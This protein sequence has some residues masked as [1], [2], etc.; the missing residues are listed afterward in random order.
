MLEVV[1]RKGQGGTVKDGA[2][3]NI[4]QLGPRPESPRLSSPTILTLVCLR[5]P[6]VTH[7]LTG[8]WLRL[9]PTTAS[10]S[11]SHLT[12]LR[13]NNWSVTGA[14]HRRIPVRQGSEQ[15][16]GHPLVRLSPEW[17][18][19]RQRPAQKNTNESDVFEDAPEH[20]CQSALERQGAEASMRLS[21]TATIFNRMF[22]SDRG[23]LV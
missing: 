21:P 10:P 22:A 6:S 13:R 14:A 1:A 8:R 12:H 3:S 15:K 19:Q 23:K 16:K 20:V 17:E 2:R 7:D 5:D 18:G 11:P 4:I 9:L